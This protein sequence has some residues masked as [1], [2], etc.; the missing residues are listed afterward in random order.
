MGKQPLL[1]LFLMNL[2]YVKPPAYSSHSAQFKWKNEKSK[3]A[4]SVENPY[5]IRWLL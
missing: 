1:Y 2:S 3:R 5:P 4:Q